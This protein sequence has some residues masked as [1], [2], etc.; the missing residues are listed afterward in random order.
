METRGWDTG[1]YKVCPVCGKAFYICEPEIWAYKLTTHRKKVREIVY[2]N[3]YSCKKK[4]EDEY[5]KEVFKI[6]QESQ[7]KQMA[8]RK[9]SNRRNAKYERHGI[10]RE[11]ECTGAEDEARCCDCRYCAKDKFGFRSCTMYGYSLNSMKLACN[12]FRAN[13]ETA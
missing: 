2:F 11:Q 12:R 9:A 6:R 8:K 1:V 13:Y 4:Y 10:I 7:K 3:K 5:E